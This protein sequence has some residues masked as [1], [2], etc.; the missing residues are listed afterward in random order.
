MPIP[1]S[2]D[3]LKSLHLRLWRENRRYG[4]HFF[5]LSKGIPIND[6]N[7]KVVNCATQTK[8]NMEASLKR[9]IIYVGRDVDDTLCHGSA[10]AIDTC[11]IIVFK[12]SAEATACF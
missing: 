7:L 2:T 10:L 1:V 11:E 5:H 4:R 3:V 12:M 8:D 6:G 9:N